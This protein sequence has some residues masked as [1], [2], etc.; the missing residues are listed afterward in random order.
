MT[1]APRF[2]AG[3]VVE[4]FT[5]NGEYS[6]ELKRFVFD[7]TETVRLGRI[8]HGPKTSRGHRYIV[9]YGYVV[10]PGTVAAKMCAQSLTDDGWLT[11][12]RPLSKE[13]TPEQRAYIDSL[14]HDDLSR[15]PNWGRDI[16]TGARKPRKKEPKQLKDKQPLLDLAVTQ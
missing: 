2:K 10:N 16:T 14:P 11:S 5:R 12:I 1:T 3:D 7:G 8:E 6:H 9:E 4:V 15:I 13:L